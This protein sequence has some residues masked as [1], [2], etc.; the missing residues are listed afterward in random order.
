[1]ISPERQI[2]ALIEAGWHVLESDFD[3]TAFRYWRMT[4]CECL[5]TL[6]GPDH[7]Y[8][9]YF[10]YKMRQSDATT[11][12]SGVGVL[13]AA[14]LSAMPSNGSADAPENRNG[15]ASPEPGAI[16]PQEGR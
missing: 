12:L 13:T 3:E 10:R 16:F 2:D 6:L 14:S 1:M 5:E 9:E 11:L 15:K 4:A 8:T 7:T